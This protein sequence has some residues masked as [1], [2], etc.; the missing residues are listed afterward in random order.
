MKKYLALFAFLF[1]FQLSA[2]AQNKSL[3][4]FNFMLGAWEMKTAKGKITETWIS[5]KDSL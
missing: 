2:D 1:V 3:K 5:K 4:Q